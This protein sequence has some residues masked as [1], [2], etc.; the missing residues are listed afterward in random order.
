MKGRDENTHH[1]KGK[2]DK[3]KQRRR[4]EKRSKENTKRK[5][6]KQGREGGLEKPNKSV[7]MTHQILTMMIQLM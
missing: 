3:E 2:N 5:E 4:E 6:K 1:A 7:T